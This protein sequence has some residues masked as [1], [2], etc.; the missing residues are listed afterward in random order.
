MTSRAGQSRLLRRRPCAPRGAVLLVLAVIIAIVH[1]AP[2]CSEPSPSVQSGAASSVTLV[3]APARS[4]CADADDAL[5]VGQADSPCAGRTCDGTSACC[6]PTGMR[7]S[8]AVTAASIA[9]TIDAGTAHD[10][11]WRADTPHSRPQGAS[12]APTPFAINCVWR[13]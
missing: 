5:G 10:A 12:R 7:E 11:G 2:L 3:A 1:L 9:V 4:A 8:D 13:T 6:L